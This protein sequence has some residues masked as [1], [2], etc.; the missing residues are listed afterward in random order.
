MTERERGG[1]CNACSPVHTVG[2]RREGEDKREGPNPPLLITLPVLLPVSSCAS[3]CTPCVPPPMPSQLLPPSPRQLLLTCQH[4]MG[5]YLSK[6][7]GIGIIS[8]WKLG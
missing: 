6:V 4:R 3:S 7:G 8:V 2:L 5:A 1:M